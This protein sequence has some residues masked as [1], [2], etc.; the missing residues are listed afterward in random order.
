MPAK[1]RHAKRRAFALSPTA[2]AAW[3]AAGPGSIEIQGGAGLILDE[4]LSEALRLPPLLW[5]PEAAAARV[6][7]V[8]AGR[9]Q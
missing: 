1:R 6:E 2:V 4:A 7:L 9:C 5:L 8:E 3:E